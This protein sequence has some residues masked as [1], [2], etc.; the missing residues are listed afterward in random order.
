MQLGC[1]LPVADIATGPAV[2]RD[3]AQAAEGLG[4][5]HPVAPVTCSVSIPAAITAVAASA[6]L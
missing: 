6:P 4:Y 1:S 3:Y 2:L 5:T